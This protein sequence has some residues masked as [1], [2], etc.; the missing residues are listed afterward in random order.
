[1]TLE[2]AHYLSRSKAKHTKAK[3]SEIESAVL[4]SRLQTADFYDFVQK[5]RVKRLIHRACG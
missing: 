1:M 4:V 5:I 2:N 3:L